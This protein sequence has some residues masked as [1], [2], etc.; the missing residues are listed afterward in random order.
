M[1]D[2]SSAIYTTCGNVP[3]P[4]D[5][6]CHL[7]VMRPGQVTSYHWASVFSSIRWKYSHGYKKYHM[8]ECRSRSQHKANIRKCLLL[9]QGPFYSW[10]VVFVKKKKK[11]NIHI[12]DKKQNS[13]G[14]LLHPSW[15]QQ[16]PLNHLWEIP[17]VIRILHK[18][19]CP[20]PWPLQLSGRITAEAD[21][22][23]WGWKGNEAQQWAPSEPHNLKSPGR[24]P[25]MARIQSWW[26]ILRARESLSQ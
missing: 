16:W 17:E 12:R 21:M 26:L 9:W 20:G 7:L 24:Q 22:D 15:A 25:A 4:N 2:I 10:P 6:V 13:S 19:R 11:K 14:M 23:C 8:R 1:H 18:S 3:V 5:Q